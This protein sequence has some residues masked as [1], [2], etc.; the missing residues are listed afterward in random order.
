[1]KCPEC[2]GQRIIHIPAEP[3]KHYRYDLT[4]PTCEGT[5]ELPDSAEFPNNCPACGEP[6]HADQKWCDHHSEAEKFFIEI[7]SQRQPGNEPSEQ[8]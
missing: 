1:M 7:C 6:I 5:G 2:D 4:C 8:I 3:G